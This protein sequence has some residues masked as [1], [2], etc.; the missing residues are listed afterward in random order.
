M[1]ELTVDE[2]ELLNEEESQLE[3]VDGASEQLSQLQEVP[4]EEDKESSDDDDDE[5]GCGFLDTAIQIQSKG[6]IALEFQRS[7]SNVSDISSCSTDKLPPFQ[8][9][10]EMDP[11]NTEE[12]LGTHEK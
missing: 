8:H 10:R 6:G 11:T 3:D 9:Q 5:E 4:E 2:E 1:S 7:T 12:V